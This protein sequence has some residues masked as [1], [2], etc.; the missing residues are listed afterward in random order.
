MKS[1]TSSHRESRIPNPESFIHARGLCD[2]DDD[3]DTDTDTERRRRPTKNTSWTTTRAVLYA[4]RGG[5]G[6]GVAE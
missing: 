2:D 1:W 6:G 3:T 5:V 4:R